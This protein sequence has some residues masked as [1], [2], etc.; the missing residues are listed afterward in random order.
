MKITVAVYPFSMELLPAVK[1]FSKLQGRYRLT[2]LI[3]PPG[4]GL[5]GKD[6]SYSCNHPEIGITVTEC[7][8][9]N[10][11]SWE[12]LFIIK[13]INRDM[14]DDAVM[15]NVM[16][17]AL[18]AGKS[19]QFF[20]NS[21]IDIS[22]KMRDMAYTHKDKIS[23]NNKSIRANDSF[24]RLTMQHLGHC[25]IE[26]PVVLVGGM[27]AEAADNFEVLAGLAEQFSKNGYRPL[28]LTRQPIG[29]VFGFYNINHVFSRSRFT[30]S[31]KIQEINTHVKFL[32]LT[33]VP[34]VILMEAPDAAMRFSN[35]KPNGHGI[36]TFMLCQAVAPDYFIITV[37]YKFAEPELLSAMST[38]FKYRL[39]SPI[40]A[41]QVSNCMLDLSMD[42][43]I[44]FVHTDIDLV[45]EQIARKRAN[46]DIKMFDVVR[47]GI[48]GMYEHINSAAL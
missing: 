42:K 40:H 39:G 29:E 34:D 24:V 4:L 28:V 32:E 31:Q 21:E 27:L 30:E 45:A 15:E 44:P 10:D 13:P 36:K 9:M 23:F 18:E 35:D 37:P 14:I 33:E 2:K 8:D 16:G 6:A 3:A 25:Q 48:S 43:E 7:L 12:T 20:V 38:G 5:S 46:S 41:V 17:R 26:A 11:P 47:D 19:V 1:Y 22:S